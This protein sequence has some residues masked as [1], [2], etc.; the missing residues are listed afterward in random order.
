MNDELLKRIERLERANRR[1]KWIGGALLVLVVAAAGM[2]Q[3]VP[4]TVAEEVAARK[5]RLVDKDGRTRATLEMVLV[6]PV[7]SLKDSDG[8]LRIHLGT[9]LGEPFLNLDTAPQAGSSLPLPTHRITL[10]ALEG[11]AAIEVCD[12]TGATRATLGV[13]ELAATSTGTK[14]TTSESSLVLF[15]KDGKV[16]YQA[17]K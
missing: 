8:S 15:D 5:F 4:A 13:T 11:R 16:I 17:G 9:F 1:M 3:A 2:A 7:L 6:D 10:G 14:T 12:R